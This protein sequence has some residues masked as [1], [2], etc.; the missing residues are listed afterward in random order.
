MT[1]RSILSFSAGLV[2]ALVLGW[3]GLP[4]LLYVGASQPL[5]FDHRLHTSERT[6][7][8]CEDCH[9]FRDDGTFTGIPRTATCAGCH[10]EPAGTS[11]DER[12]LVSDY[13]QA[14]REIPWRVYARQPDNVHFSHAA[15]V[16]RA[17]IACERCHGAHGTSEALRPYARDRITG[18]GRDLGGPALVRVG[19]SSR[20][21]LTMSDCEAC[22][23]ERG[24]GRTACLACHK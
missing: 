19:G 8:S 2:P 22:H 5:A 23:K 6:G 24:L 21:G 15:H 13:V 16:K 3:L 20:P 9:S 14:G 12:R 18:Y 1:S 10:S 7:L 17:R 4:R 11:E